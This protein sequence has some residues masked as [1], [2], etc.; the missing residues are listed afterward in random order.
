M[1][2]RS[3]IK[4]LIHDTEGTTAVEYAVMLA[5]ILVTM[6]VGITAAGSGV[7]DWWNTINTELDNNGF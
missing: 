7:S 2:I 3:A 1:Y 6:I 5:L 4:R